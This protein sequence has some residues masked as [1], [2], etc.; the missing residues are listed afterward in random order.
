MAEISVIVPVYQA[1]C[2]LSQCV[3][4]ILNQSFQD[5]EV[6]LVDDGSTDGSGGICDGYAARDGRITAVHQENQGQ[7]AARNRAMGIAKGNWFCFVDSD[8]LIH[9]RMLEW[10]Y[11]AAQDSGAAISQ[12]RMLE[13]P[14]LPGDFH[15]E[16]DPAYQLLPMDEETL[17]ACFDRGEYPGWV[18]CAKLVRR[19]IAER[20][21]FTPGRV[22]EDNEAVCH[23]ILAAGQIADIPQQLYFYRTNPDSTT[24]KTFGLK[25]LDYLWALERIMTLYTGRG[26][27][28][29]CRRFGDLYAEA[30]AGCYWRVKYELKLP[31]VARQIR[32]DIRKTVLSKRLTKGQLEVLFDALHPRLIGLYWPVE[33]CVRTLRQEGLGSLLKKIQKQLRKGETHDP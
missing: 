18:A 21:P 20:K 26:Y 25:R 22:Y 3:D 23:W 7:A 31:R 28:R 17:L 29:L 16:R 2:Y 19:E 13:A 30:A 12:C 6:I 11:Q 24:Q 1:Q 9:P 15:R 14:E 10:L 5:L 33:G 8:D 32:R 27:T 4:S